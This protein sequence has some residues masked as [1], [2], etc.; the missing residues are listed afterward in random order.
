MIIGFEQVFYS[1]VVRRKFTLSDKEDKVEG[2]LIVLFF[3]LV[4]LIAN[5]K[6]LQYLLNALHTS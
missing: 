1:L 4:F 6:W 2:C 3:G 5:F